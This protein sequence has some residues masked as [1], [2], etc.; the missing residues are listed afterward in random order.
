MRKS[1]YI[2]QIIESVNVFVAKFCWK[3]YRAMIKDWFLKIDNWF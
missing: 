2:L 1:K 3:D